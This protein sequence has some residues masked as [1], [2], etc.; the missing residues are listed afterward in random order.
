MNEPE[1]DEATGVETTGHEWDGIKELNNPLPRWWLW[2]FYG[3]IGI[4]VAISI[5]Y[6]AWPLWGGATPGLL[7]YST[8]GD[9]NADL[10]AAQAGQAANIAKIAATPVAQI[11]ADPELSRYAIAGGA[12]AF[13]VTCAQCH[14]TGA[15]G[16]IGYPNLNDDEWI[17]GGSIDNIYATIT[18]GARDPNDTDT[19]MNIMPNF[20]T[21]ALLTGDQIGTVAAYVASLSGLPGGKSTP[22]G[23]KLFADNCA[24]CHGDNAKGKPDLGG[25]DLTDQIWLYHGSLDAIIAQVTHPRHGSM[26]AWGKRLGDTTV[27]ELAVY[28][29]SLGGGK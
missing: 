9:L 20:G 1:I 27:K 17:W 16:G 23:I 12:S 4:G 11:A 29:H 21:D 24:A 19:H 14:G 5:L 26:P 13:K 2:T 6:P 8:R 18:H 25:P 28:V 3:C 15:E 7:H 10:A 22:E